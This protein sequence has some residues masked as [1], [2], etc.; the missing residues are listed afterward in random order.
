VEAV[1]ERLVVEVEKQGV[2]MAKTQEV[3]PIAN[4]LLL[5]SHSL[6]VRRVSGLTTTAE[7]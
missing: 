6:G 2:E 4:C 7:W 1:S 3:V 5:Q